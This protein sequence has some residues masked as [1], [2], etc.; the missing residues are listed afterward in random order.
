MWGQ[1]LLSEK[2]TLWS[3]Y[4]GRGGASQHPG[5]WRM[6]E[7]KIGDPHTLTDHLAQGPKCWSIRPLPDWFGLER[8]LFKRYT[9]TNS[10]DSL[11][12]LPEILGSLVYGEAQDLYL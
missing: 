12:Q 11:A 10:V 1:G 7:V 2:P 6:A 3:V 5:F 9:I 8:R 4:Q